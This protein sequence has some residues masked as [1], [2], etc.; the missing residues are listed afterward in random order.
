M[1]TPEGLAYVKQYMKAGQT[2]GKYTATE[3]G[4]LSDQELIFDFTYDMSADA[5]GDGGHQGLTQDILLDFGTQ[6]YNLESVLREYDPETAKKVWDMSQ[7][8]VIK[9][10]T[11]I[12]LYPQNLS[13]VQGSPEDILE[14]QALQL[15]HTIGHELFIH[16]DPISSVIIEAVIENDFELA[17]EAAHID[18]DAETDKKGHSTHVGYRDN[19]PDF[20]LMKDF[21]RSL[22]R[23]YK[24]AAKVIKRHDK[25]NRGNTRNKR[26]KYKGLPKGPTQPGDAGHK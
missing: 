9:T 4:E 25:S 23:M 2:V 17:Y 24:K 11:T 7:P 16:F 15:A 19:S 22:L 20:K 8:Y 6:R 13:Y 14:E 18:Y 5:G 26:F 10:S 3:N 21:Q 12:T 1:S